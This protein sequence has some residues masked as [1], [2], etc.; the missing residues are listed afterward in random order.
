[1]ARW[2][3]FAIATVPTVPAFVLVVS[4]V[5]TPIWPLPGWN[6]R[7]VILLIVLTGI[8]QVVVIVSGSASPKILKLPVPL[9]SSQKLILWG[10][11]EGLAGIAL[12]QV[13]SPTYL[14]LGCTFLVYL[15]FAAALL[16]VV[17][18]TIQT[19]GP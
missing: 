14:W 19:R 9:S 7:D 11:Y 10:L 17:K 12:I 1:M 2:K 5:G 13:F 16:G 6:W 15:G 18:V 4:W 8:I 3:A